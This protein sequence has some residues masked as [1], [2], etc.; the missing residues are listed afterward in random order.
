MLLRQTLIYGLGNIIPGL[1]ATALVALYTRMLTPE[2][3][4]LFVLVMTVIE[5][6]WS[7]SLSWLTTAMV[8][9]YP[10]QTD[11]NRFLGIILTIFLATIA[12][13]LIACAVLIGLLDDPRHRILALLGLGLF[14]ATGWMEL[15]SGLFAARLEARRS[16][17]TLI[18][19]SLGSG[20]FAG[21]FVL[22]GYGAEGILIGATIGM[23]LPGLFQIVRD[24]RVASGIGNIDGMGEIARVGAPLAGGIAMGSIGAYAGRIIV[25]ALEGVSALGLYSISAELAD[26]L[27]TGILGPLSTALGPLATHDLENANVKAAQERLSKACI[28]MVGIMAPATIGVTMVTPDIVAVLIGGEF[29][30]ITQSLLPLATL[31]TMLWAFRSGYLDQALHLGMKQDFL[32]YREVIY[33][34]V[35]VA[36]SYV[37][38]SWYGILGV[39]YASVATTAIMLLVTYQFVRKAFPLPFPLMDIAKISLATTLMAVAVALVPGDP[40]LINLCLKPAVGAVVYALLILALNVSWSRET[41]TDALKVRFAA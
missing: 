35:T 19:R 30:E 9:L 21:G 14:I 23:F 8:R 3:F 10:K 31:S 40:G 2:E 28:L 34:F 18:S 39:A 20:L 24:W 25:T 36:N 29:K 4:G 1:V 33:L 5:F 32:F 7:L 11:K 38:I 13:A 26:R 15:N 41:V 37:L 27:V 12:L 22:S 17:F 6:S 16:A